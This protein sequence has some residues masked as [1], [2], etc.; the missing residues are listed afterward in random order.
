MGILV[1]VNNA[2]VLQLDVE[3]LVNRV[4]H[5]ADRQIILELHCHLL[6]HELLEVGEEQL[7]AQEEGRRVNRTPP[8]P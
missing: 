1:L 6:P 3:V 2:G 7:Q 4:E 8:P 5:P